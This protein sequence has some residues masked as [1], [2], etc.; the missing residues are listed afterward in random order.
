MQTKIRHLRKRLKNSEDF[1]KE[2]ISLFK[3][4]EYSVIE[5]EKLYGLR[6]PT[7]YNWIYKYSK[8]NNKAIRLV[9]MKQNCS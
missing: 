6:S 2:I 5:L 7:I 3:K 1:K 9:E 4:R 8:F